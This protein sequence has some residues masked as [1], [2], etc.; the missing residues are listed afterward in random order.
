MNPF[1]EELVRTLKFQTVTT[2][3][4]L[5]AAKAQ[6]SGLQAISPTKSPAK[7]APTGSPFPSFLRKLATTEPSLEPEATSK[8]LLE[9][10]RLEIG[11]V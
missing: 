10:A 6:S 5:T 3:L 7:A 9:K 11:S 1:E 2:P 4:A 8:P